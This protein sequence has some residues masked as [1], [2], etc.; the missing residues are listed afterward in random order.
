MKYYSNSRQDLKA[1]LFPADRALTIGV[2]DSTSPV[3]IS[4]TIAFQGQIILSREG[5]NHWL[6]RVYYFQEMTFGVQ[7]AITTIRDS[8]NQRRPIVDYSSR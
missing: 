6:P 5:V 7:S 2:Q 3:K 8:F 4:L 1:R